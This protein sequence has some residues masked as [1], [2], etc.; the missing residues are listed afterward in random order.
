MKQIEFKHGV[1]EVYETKEEI[2]GIL[3]EYLGKDE[4]EWALHDSRFKDC[5]N[6]N[7]EESHYIKKVVAI[8][9]PSEARKTL[10]CFE[11]WNY[12]YDCHSHK[13][14]EL[15][16]NTYSSGF[17]CT[18]FKRPNEEKQK[19]FLEYYDTVRDDDRIEKILNTFKVGDKLYFKDYDS[20]T[21]SCET[22]NHIG[23]DC[24]E[25]F[26]VEVGT[27]ERD[28]KFAICNMNK[29]GSCRAYCDKTLYTSLEAAKESCLGDLCSLKDEYKKKISTIEKK[30]V[31]AMSF[32]G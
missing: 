31:N 12:E 18:S 22:V 17:A 24:Y 1:V 14:V 10:L 15:D 28:R 6:P 23:L 27:N 11:H 9:V 32:V 16:M 13:N 8:K 4:V 7:T 5:F 21:L 2:I 25:E 29:D 20:K 26:V 19:C 30:I 3:S